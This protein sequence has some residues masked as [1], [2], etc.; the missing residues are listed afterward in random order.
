M[1]AERF[2]SRRLRFEGTLVMTSVALSFLVIILAVTVS[3]GFRHE[4]RSAA[5]SVSGDIQISP[6]TADYSLE[7]DPVPAEPSY[8]EDLKAIEGVRDVSPVIYR[9]GIVRSGGTVHGVL[10]KGTGADTAR[11]GVRIPRHLALMLSLGEGDSMTAYFVGENVKVRKWHITQVY[12]PVL[13]TDA[14]AVVYAPLTDMRRLNGWEEGTASALEVTM[15]GS[16]RSKSAL[17]EASSKAGTIIV[18]QA[19]D[20]DE[21]LVSIPVNRRWPR[22]FGWLDLLDF[23]VMTVLLLMIAVAAFNMVSGLLIML[24]RHIPTI[25]ILKAMGMDNRGVSRVFLQLSSRLVLKGMAAGNAVSLLFCLVQ[26]CTHFVKLNPENYFVS[27]VPVHVNLP[28][29]LC[30]DLIAYVAI[31]LVLLIPCRFISGVDPARTVKAD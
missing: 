17:E 25:G 28:W 19:Q 8:L 11:L 13:E 14:S 29:I 30:A 26:G 7:D 23:N 22:L 2:I 24:F 4:I 3:S 1:S 5:A 9:T 6:R 18:M 21:E 27:F 16:H 10:F 20:A 12:D 31:M 15:D